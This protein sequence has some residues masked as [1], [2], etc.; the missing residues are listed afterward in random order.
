MRT[1]ILL[2][3]F[4]TGC[5]FSAAARVNPETDKDVLILAILVQDHLR[6]TG[7]RDTVLSTLLQADT[8]NR[9]SRCFEKVEFRSRPGY[10]SVYYTF[11][12]SRKLKSI[13][14]TDSEWERAESFRRRSR[15]L[16]TPF[17]GEIRLDYG[18]RFYRII[19]IIINTRDLEASL[20]RK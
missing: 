10:I 9:I 2:A 3:I 17:D 18:E 12:A 6:K 20:S 1:I 19:R 16:S 15:K 14:L 11:S 8:L 4:L 5:L 7:G 13:T